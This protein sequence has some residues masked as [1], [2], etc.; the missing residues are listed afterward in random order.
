MNNEAKLALFDDVVEENEQLREHYNEMCKQ[1]HDLS[2]ALYQAKESLDATSRTI[3]L[4]IDR[5][6]E[7]VEKKRKVKK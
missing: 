3:S 5:P 4:L 6:D 1:I 2:K 7:V